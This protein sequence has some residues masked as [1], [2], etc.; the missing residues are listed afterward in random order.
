MLKLTCDKEVRL[1]CPLFLFRIKKSLLLFLSSI[2]VHVSP[3][4]HVHYLCC[5]SVGVV[6]LSW[7]LTGE[8]AALIKDFCYLAVNMSSFGKVVGDN[9]E[10]Q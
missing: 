10:Q 5:C 6:T 3:R 1:K 2:V 9:L 8:C 7:L 4:G